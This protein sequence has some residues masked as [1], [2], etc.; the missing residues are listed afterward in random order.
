MGVREDRLSAEYR[1][2]QRFRSDVLDWKADGPSASPD[3]YVVTYKLK[4]IIGFSDKNPQYHT[5]F[6]VKIGFP[7]DYPR[8]KPEVRLTSTSRPFHPNIW[9]RDGRFCLE[10]NQNWI[11]GIG[12][13]LD[14]LCQMIGEIIAFQHINLKSPANGDSTL[15]NW[16]RSNPSKLP[17]D[18]TPIRLADAV[19]TIQWGTSEDAPPPTRIRFG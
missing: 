14:S 12:V 13:P 9:V 6:T 15:V 17:V 2:M 7:S 19:D 3:V 18:P 5:G 1:A 16:I 8:S 11:P 10:G 4:S